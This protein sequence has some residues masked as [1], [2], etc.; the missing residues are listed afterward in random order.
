M[1]AESFP[2]KT[3]DGTNLTNVTLATE[4]DRVSK[5]TQDVNKITNVAL[6]HRD[7]KVIYACNI[8]DKS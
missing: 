5:K 2:K 1:S 7:E 4:D 8:C 6:A 3:Q